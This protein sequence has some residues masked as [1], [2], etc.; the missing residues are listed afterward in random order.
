LAKEELDQARRWLLLST[1]KKREKDFQKGQ[2]R[3]RMTGELRNSSKH[4]GR[5]AA[6]SNRERMLN[7]PRIVIYTLCN[8]G[9]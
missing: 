2:S 4:G 3:K 9:T 8:A 5:F 6:T 1:A 7:L